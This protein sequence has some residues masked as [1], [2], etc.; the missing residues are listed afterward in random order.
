MMIFLNISLIFIAIGSVISVNVAEY[1]GYT[2]LIKLS[3]IM[4]SLSLILSS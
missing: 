3:A 2:R 1:M 4:Q